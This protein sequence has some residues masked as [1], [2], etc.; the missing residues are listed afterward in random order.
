MKSDIIRCKIANSKDEFVPSSA[1]GVGISNVKKR[2]ELLYSS[3]YELK[4]ND[5]GNFFVVSLMV[6][7]ASDTRAYADTS[8][9]VMIPQTRLHE[10]PL[11]VYR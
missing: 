11:P 6:K 1:Y 5:D 2:L 8:V 10:S 9:P 7:L 4:L 3:R